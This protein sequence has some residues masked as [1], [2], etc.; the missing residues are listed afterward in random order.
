MSTSQTQVITTSVP[1]KPRNCNCDVTMRLCYL[2]CGELKTF[3]YLDFEMGIGGTRITRDLC[4]CQKFLMGVG[5]KKK[6][7]SH[8]TDAGQTIRIYELKACPELIELI[9]DYWVIDTLAYIKGKK[10]NEL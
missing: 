7:W 2:T 9:N 6:S 5:G 8:D 1:Y 3:Y 10:T 4:D